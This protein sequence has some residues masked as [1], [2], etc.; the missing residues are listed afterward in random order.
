MVCRNS[1]SPSQQLGPTGERG[2]GHI[3]GGGGRRRG[4]RGG[5]GGEG[6]I[7]RERWQTI[8]LIPFHH[9]T[10]HVIH[11]LLPS[12][13]GHQARGETPEASRETPH[14]REARENRKGV[15]SSYKRSEEWR[16][17]AERGCGGFQGI[18]QLSRDVIQPHQQN[19]SH[20][21]DRVHPSS[22]QP[23]GGQD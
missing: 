6:G 13:S 17:R 22:E 19:Q 8:Q 4:G 20:E 23:R 7:W 21:Q 9:H 3:G 12:L 11:L 14:T 18:H 5:G 15:P 1:P 16:R 2:R 10:A